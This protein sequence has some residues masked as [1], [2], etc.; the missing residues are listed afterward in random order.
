MA[1]ILQMKVKFINS[2]KAT[3]FCKIFHLLLTV[4]TVV[5]SLENISQNFVAFSEYM[6]FNFCKP[7]LSGFKTSEDCLDL[8]SC[9]GHFR[10]LE[11]NIFSGSIFTIC[12]LYG[13][14]CH[15]HICPFPFGW[16]LLLSKLEAPIQPDL[17]SDVET[18]TVDTSFFFT[19]KKSNVTKC[20]AEMAQ[21]RRKS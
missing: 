6:N 10:I 3:T 19:K 4:C 1:F 8:D 17:L 20:N 16:F 5:K 21:W 12:P 13:K 18:H 7:Y 9:L 2:E 14:S 15:N 11:I